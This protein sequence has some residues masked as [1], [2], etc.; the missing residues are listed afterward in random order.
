CDVTIVSTGAVLKMVIDAAE[1]LS[2]QDYSVEIINMHTLQPLDS[3]AV[4][5]SV[6]KTGKVIT[7][8]EHGPGGLG[9]V[10]AEKLAGIKCIFVP[11]R[12]QQCPATTAGSQE[13]LRTSH[14]VSVESIT[15]TVKQMM[16]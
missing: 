6:Q 9:T 1:E 13:T 4:L 2:Q 5:Q 3:K 12:L 16:G 8:E 11:L 15:N 7:V 14:G 10:V